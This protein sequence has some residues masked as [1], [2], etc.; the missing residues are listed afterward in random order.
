VSFGY[1][2]AWLP[3]EKIRDEL[4]N[5]KLKP[6]PLKEGQ[7]IMIPLYLIFADP[8]YAGPGTQR[9]AQIVR[10]VIAENS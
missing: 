6:L 9:L 5:E 8:E 10:D 3:E 4:Q 2:F 1:G 7:E